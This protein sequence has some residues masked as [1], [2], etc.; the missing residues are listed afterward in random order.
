MLEH[1]NPWS[2]LGFETPFCPT[3]FLYVHAPYDEVWLSFESDF[4]LRYLPRHS[5]LI[6]VPQVHS[7]R[8]V[9]G[10]TER[11]DPRRRGGTGCGS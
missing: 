3:P 2:A 1:R 4:Y 6:L 5:S 8:G 11:A 7:P 9:Y 10:L